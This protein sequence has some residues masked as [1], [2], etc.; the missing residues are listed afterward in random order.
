MR[1]SRS[2]LRRCSINFDFLG[3]LG[4]CTS[5]TDGDVCL[6]I[7]LPPNADLS[8]LPEWEMRNDNQESKKITD[9][10]GGVRVG[11]VAS[12]WPAGGWNESALKGTDL[13]R[14]LTFRVNLYLLLTLWSICTICCGEFLNK[15]QAGQIE[16]VSVP[17]SERWVI[18]QRHQDVPSLESWS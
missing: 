8:P 1:K 10:L 18:G 15:T 14:P 17:V 13:S 2:A 9:R 5:L 3:P 6:E 7:Y 16:R 11:C 12:G 4:G